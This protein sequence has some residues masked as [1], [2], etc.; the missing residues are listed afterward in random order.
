MEGAYHGDFAAGENSSN[1]LFDFGFR[2]LDC[3]VALSRDRGLSDLC[4]DRPA[5][6]TRRLKGARV[7]EREVPSVFKL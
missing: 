4:R 6:E 3:P 7:A 5:S 1:S 2:R